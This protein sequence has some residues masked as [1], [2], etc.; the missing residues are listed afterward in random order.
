[1]EVIRWYIH[2]SI[3]QQQDQILLETPSLL[4]PSLNSSFSR[5]RFFR[6]RQWAEN[7]E[8]RENR[9]EQMWILSILDLFCQNMGDI[10]RWYTWKSGTEVRRIKE[11]ERKRERGVF[12]FRRA[13]YW[14]HA[15][16]SPWKVREIW[17][18]RDR[19]DLSLHYIE[20]N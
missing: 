8:W 1:M 13:I 17:S 14:T 6:I 3:H 12:T 18:K 15:C 4:S 7:L 2:S 11:K 19:N 16:M 20:W 5:R 9:L 10:Y